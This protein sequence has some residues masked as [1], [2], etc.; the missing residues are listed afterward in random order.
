MVFRLTQRSGGATRSR[1]RAGTESQLRGCEA[2]GGH[3]QLRDGQPALEREGGGG[4]G[5]VERSKEKGFEYLREVAN[6]SGENSVDARVV[7]SLFL[8]RERHYD[9]A[10]AL[11]HDLAARYPRNYLL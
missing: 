9:E 1:T 7:L 11:M 6:S 4:D 8:R 10:R 5:G 3:A 2:G